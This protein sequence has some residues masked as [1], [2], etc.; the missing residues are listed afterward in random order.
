M[1]DTDLKIKEMSLSTHSCSSAG[2]VLPL[3]VRLERFS[4]SETETNYR[5]NYTMSAGAEVGAEDHSDLENICTT[6]ESQNVHFELCL[7]FLFHRKSA[8]LSD[9]SAATGGPSGGHLL[10]DG[11]V[12]VYV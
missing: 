1:G 4:H 8:D 9:S 12:S 6:L 10:P 5:R 7:S 3:T 2:E 11:P